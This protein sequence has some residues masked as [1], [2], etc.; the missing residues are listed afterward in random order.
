MRALIDNDVFCKLEVCGLLDVALK[1]LGLAPE[2]CACLKTLPYVLKRGRLHDQYGDG[3]SRRLAGGVGRFA[4]VPE[5]PEVWKEQLTG[6]HEIDPGEAAIFGAAADAPDT[7]AV[8]GDKRA[9]KALSGL[10]ALSSS[11]AGRVVCLEALVLCLI[12]A[13]GID[14]VAKGIEPALAF[15]G[16]LQ[17][18][19]TSGDPTAGLRSY[20]RALQEDASPGL[21][22]ST[23]VMP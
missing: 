9:I 14:F 19:F 2:A 5:L 4:A 1:S 18:C 13:R 22:Y 15:D 12:A 8:T 10:P 16:A 21:L 3:V 11:L 23:G 7:L 17:V 6:S 20:F